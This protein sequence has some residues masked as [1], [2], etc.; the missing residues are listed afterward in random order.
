MSNLLDDGIHIAKR[1]D[2][3]SDFITQWTSLFKRCFGGTQKTA[4]RV[5]QKYQLNDSRICYSVKN[6]I[7]IAA[8][9]GLKLSHEGSAVFLSTDTMSDGTQKG[10]SITLGKRLYKTFPEEEISVVCGYPNKNI[11]AI[12]ERGLGW[13]LEGNLY[14]YIG[15]PFL[16]HLFRK[17]INET[18]LWKAIRPKDGWYTR[19]KPLLVNLLGRDGLFTSSAGLVITLSAYRPGIF[20]IKAP[21]FLFEPRWFGYRFLTEDTE[22]NKA[23]L[24]KVKF[25][26]LDTIDI[27]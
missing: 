13:T 20:F 14:L 5:F 26:D 6:G 21:D 17:K 19:E 9:C 25:L 11:R 27:P 12:R 23:F 15:I 7:M 3:N 10:S 1:S 16:W 24:R 4:D 8:Y 2:F 22:T 18:L